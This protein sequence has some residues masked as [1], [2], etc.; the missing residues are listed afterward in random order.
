M[1]LKVNR[2][3]WKLFPSVEEAQLTVNLI[4]IEIQIFGTF[5]N[6]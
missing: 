4:Q 6:L 5:D 3:F 1:I 2:N